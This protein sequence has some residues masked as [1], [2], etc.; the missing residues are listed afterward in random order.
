MKQSLL[1]LPKYYT[2]ITPFSSTLAILLFISFPILA[3]IIGMRH[4]QIIDVSIPHQIA[5]EFT[6][7]S[8]QKTDNLR[9]PYNP[10][11]TMPY[12]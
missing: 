7:F 8:L 4:Q 6:N 12:K 3:F 5:T 9:Q 11:P 1:N 2:T 10:K